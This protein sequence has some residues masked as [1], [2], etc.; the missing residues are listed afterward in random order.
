MPTDCERHG[1]GLASL[2]RLRG[3]TTNTCATLAG[4][5]AA[6]WAEWEAGRGWPTEITV[7]AVFG[8]GRET[9]MRLGEARAE[10]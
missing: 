1:Q 6:Q 7:R 8:V 5:T 2:R 9:V 4:V 3:L 10:T